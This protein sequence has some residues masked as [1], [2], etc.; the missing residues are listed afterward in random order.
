M[1]FNPSTEF[2]SMVKKIDDLAGTNSTTY[3]LTKKARAVNTG[4]DEAYSLLLQYTDTKNYDDH[5]FSNIPQGTY[6]ITIGERNLSVFK[7]EDGA[8]ILKIHKVIAKNSNG[9]WYE[10]KEMD[11][12]SK[13]AD[14]IAY[15]TET[16]QISAYD[17]VGTSMVF[18]VT[19]EATIANGIKVFY[20]R[21][22][23]YFTEDDTTKEPGLPAIYHMYAVFYAAWE[24]CFSKGL[25]KATGYE[26]KL[27][28]MREEMKKFASSQTLVENT[29]MSPLKVN[30][31]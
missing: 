26:K 25:Q 23:S 11:I 2:D 9:D 27:K 13:N 21:N 24:H 29:R 22:S 28:E 19:P 6:D 5:N 15:G 1:K 17:W 20:A 30:A 12:R 7:D 8:E 16:G 18:D 4:L 10:L 3:P 14:N 31:K